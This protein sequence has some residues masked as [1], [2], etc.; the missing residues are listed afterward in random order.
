MTKVLRIIYNFFA[1]LIILFFLFTAV[2]A[3]SDTKV[4]AVATGSMEPAIPNGSVVFVRPRAE[5][6]VGDVITA[7]LEGDQ[8]FTHRIVDKDGEQV[9]TKGDA[10]A[11]VDESPTPQSRI[12]GKVVFHLPLLGFLSQKLSVNSLLI[13]FAA[14]LTVLIAVRLAVALK[15][16]RRGDHADEKNR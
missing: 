3:V 1:I 2:V 7:F 8:T 12:V 5:Y 11:S 15:Q 10:N 9:Y 14:V 4:Y 13:A 6:R 16:K